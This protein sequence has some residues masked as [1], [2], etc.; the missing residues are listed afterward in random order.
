MYH[1]QRWIGGWRWTA[2]LE[3]WFRA[4][5]KLA[6][7]VR[8]D[9]ERRRLDLCR[10]RALRYQRKLA[11]EGTP[12]RSILRHIKEKMRAARAVRS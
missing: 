10:R 11:R 12:H 7:E 5:P 3:Q 1:G 9:L 2:K 6:G 8:D 4:L